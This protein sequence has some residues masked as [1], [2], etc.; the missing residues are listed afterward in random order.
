MHAWRRMHWR[1]MELLHALEAACMHGVA[2]CGIGGCRAHAHFE[3]GWRA[4]LAGELL[5]PFG[6][7]C[8]LCCWCCCLCCCCCCCYCLCCC[9]CCLCCLCC[10][11]CLCCLCCFCLCSVRRLTPARP[12]APDRAPGRHALV[13]HGCT[14]AWLHGLHGVH[15]LR[16]HAPGLHTFLTAVNQLSLASHTTSYP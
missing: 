4:A 8:C 6:C 7:C 14:A 10:Y 12:P 16:L 11:C 13:L 15:A 2:A 9:L 5:A 3:R 1:R